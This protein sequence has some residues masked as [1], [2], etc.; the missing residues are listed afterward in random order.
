MTASKNFG[1]ALCAAEAA[2]D[3]RFH[4]ARAL[5]D[6]DLRQDALWAAESMLDSEIKLALWNLERV[7]M[8][9]AAALVDRYNSRVY[10]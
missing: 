3:K 8:K 9:A 4:E 1:D 5:T 2:Y 10:P 7:V 6:P